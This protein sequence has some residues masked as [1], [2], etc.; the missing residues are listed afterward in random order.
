MNTKVKLRNSIS[1]KILLLVSF[2]MIISLAFT[3]LSSIPY[4][5]NHMEETIHDY[6]IDEVKAYGLALDQLVYSNSSRALENEEALKS[7][8][9]GVNVHKIKSSYAY[10]VKSDSTMLFHPTPEK[11]GKPVENEVVKDIIEKI[12]KGQVPQPDCIEYTFKGSQKYASYYVVRDQSCILVITADKTDIFKPIKDTRTRMI[13]VGL[14]ILVLLQVISFFTVKAII[15]PLQKITSIINKVASLDFTKDEQQEKLN[16][17]TDEIGDISRSISNLHSELSTVISIISNQSNLVNESCSQFNNGFSSIAE[18][19]YSMNLAIEGISE[20]STS[21]AQETL[22]ANNLVK[23]S[24][25]SVDSSI[26]YIEILNDSI[27]KMNSYADKA[28]TSFV[29]LIEICNKMSS[30]IEVILAQTNVT[31]TS[32]NKINEAVTLIQ[33]IAEQT[34]LLSLNASIEA[35]RAGEAGKGFSVVADEIRNLSDGSNKSAQQI[36]MIVRELITNSDVSVSKMKEISDDAALQIKKLSD[37]KLSF[38]G[39]EHE[40]ES[41]SNAFQDIIT[42][43]QNLKAINSS[44]NDVFAELSSLAQE[45]ASSAE[46]T[47]ANMQILSETIEGCKVQTNNLEELSVEL[48]QQ[49]GKFVF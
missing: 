21:Q 15:K 43:I 49:V 11:I 31:N 30:N 33:D 24:S 32:A 38:D 42:Q 48:E 5:S 28:Y 18:N 39:L 2:G 46:E 29:S 19:I 27:S 12:N 40:I 26:N 4:I 1:S 8:L 35:A 37:T 34:N 45:N 7:I 23:N 25:N 41:V 10:L 16:T 36:D 14:F 9:E 44:V 20:G 17:R 13:I 47:S 22:S 6:M 3:I